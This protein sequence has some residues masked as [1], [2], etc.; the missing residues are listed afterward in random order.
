MDAHELP[1][2]PIS[3]AD[4]VAPPAP[5]MIE[6]SFQF[7]PVTPELLQAVVDDFIAG[8]KMDERGELEHYHKHHVA[9]FNGKVVGADKNV[10][11][12]RDRMVR[13][14]IVPEERLVV[15]FIGDDTI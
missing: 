3:A 4:V 7:D 11:E 2:A 9:I 13:E 15:I 14:G 12:L 8:W 10:A 6:P 5:P 1:T